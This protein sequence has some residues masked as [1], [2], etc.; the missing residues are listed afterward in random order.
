MQLVPELAPVWYATCAQE[1][2]QASTRMRVCR[3]RCIEKSGQ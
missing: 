2:M 1:S 3:L